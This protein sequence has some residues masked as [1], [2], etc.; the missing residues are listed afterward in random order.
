MARSRPWDRLTGRIGK[1]DRY[2]TMVLTERERVRELREQIRVLKTEAERY[3]ALDIVAREGA[4]LAEAVVEL[5]RSGS[6]TANR[7]YVRAIC[8]ALMEDPAQMDLGHLAFGVFLVQE[9]LYVAAESYFALVGV[10]VAR[11]AVPVEYFMARFAADVD[12]SE[13]ELVAFLDERRDNLSHAEHLQLL[14]ILA[15]HL[16]V[17]TLVA[18]LP[19]LVARE[20][21]DP[22]L[23]ETGAQ[24]LAWMV[25]RL[26]DYGK[27]APAV[28]RGTVSLAVM[29]YKLLDRSRTSSN[30]GDYVQTLAALANICRFSDVEFT[31]DSELSQ[32]LTE[33]QGEIRPER[34]IEGVHAKVLPVAL[35]RDFASGRSYPDNTWLLCNGWFMHRN[36][37]GEIDFPF[38]DT[39]NP[40]FLSFHVQDPDLLDEE[41]AEKLRQHEPIGCRD[42]TTV[43]RLADFGVK[44]FFAGCLTTTVSQVMPPVTETDADRVA[45]VEAKATPGELDG[46]QVDEVSQVGDFVRDFSLVEAV[47]DARAMLTEYLPVSKVITNRLH[48]YL[49]ARSMGLKVDFR[50]KNPS[51]I[52]FEGLLRLTPEQFQQMRTG[53]ED[54]LETILRAILQG[55]SRSE[56]M[57]LWRELAVRDVE[58]AD[59][60]RATY[61]EPQPTTIDVAAVLDETRSSAVRW[62]SA[63]GEPGDVTVAFAIDQNLKDQLAVVLQSVADT[64]R[65]RIDVHV[66][67]RGLDIDYYERLHALVPEFALTFYSFDGIDYGDQLRM[68]SHITVSTMDRLFLPEL[69]SD[70]DKVLYLDTD[71]LVQADVADLYEIDLGDHVLAAKQSNLRTWKNVVRLVTRAS[72]SLPPEKAWALRRRLHHTHHLNAPTFNAG[73]ILLNLQLMREERFTDEYLHLVENYAFNDQD[74]LNV[75][76]GERVTYLDSAWNH[77]PNQDF[78]EVPRIIHWAGPCK[79]WKDLYV[80][81]KPRYDTV[82][83]RVVA[84]SIAE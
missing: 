63:S 42:W 45:L 46:K 30:R 9:E 43:Y 83:E 56:V 61:P 62:P 40:I 41:V 29:E 55:G 58:A 25:K 49:P 19:H 21:I 11:R 22:Q 36:Y 60:Y 28:D 77:V 74:V 8:Q 72:M 15:K 35:D 80:W 38:P 1:A 64:T 78:Y 39:V 54:R 65:A 31:G 44:A 26:E 50:P 48:C 24:Q 20:G 82:L 12:A 81:G 51:D 70:V 66:M 17:S 27:P 67:G 4:P 33:L 84:T 3:Q 5:V 52:R 2:R 79:P 59:R 14:T 13:V 37:R 6:T 18:E 75:Y 47:R 69:L 16:K 34:R 32:L 7:E 68:L 71:I 10:G 57:A 23:D 73:V 53:I 76:A